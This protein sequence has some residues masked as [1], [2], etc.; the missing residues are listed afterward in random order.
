MLGIR[1]LRV[2]NTVG[3]KHALNPKSHK[4]K[5]STAWLV[6]LRALI[7]EQSLARQASAPETAGKGAGKQILICGLRFA[8]N[9]TGVF[10]DEKRHPHPDFFLIFFHNRSQQ[11]HQL[12]ALFGVFFAGYFHAEL[13]H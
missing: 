1:N 9:H 5:A 13:A 4:Y 8:V 11:S 6:T 7:R 2:F 3:N 12:L 10:L